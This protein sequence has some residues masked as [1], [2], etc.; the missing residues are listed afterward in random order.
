MVGSLQA[1]QIGG[2]RQFSKKK[3][4]KGDKDTQ[5]ESAPAQNGPGGSEGGLD[6]EGP[7]LEMDEL[8]ESFEE[9]VRK[10]RA[11]RVTAELIEDLKVQVYGDWSPLKMVSQISVRDANNLVVNVHD[12][13]LLDDVEFGIRHHDQMDLTAKVE[14]KRVVVTFPRV[15]KESR[16]DL[17]KA[18][19]QNG[20]KAKGSIRK[21]R[22]RALDGLKSSSAT[23]DEQFEF[24]ADIQALVDKAN[25]RVE[26]VLKKKETEIMQVT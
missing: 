1:S 26:E 25:K 2:R 5:V 19:K 3:K 4:K 17:V 23:K 15:T 8:F 14:G 21:V 11:G 7:E 13:T 10:M 6:L 12:P 16:Q 9:D 18:V 22:Q 24:K 20:E